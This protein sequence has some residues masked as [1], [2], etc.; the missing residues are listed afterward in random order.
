LCPEASI[1]RARWVLLGAYVAQLVLG[2]VNVILLAPIPIQLFHL[3]LADT[4]WVVFIM[5]VVLALKR[6][7][8]DA[9]AV[10]VA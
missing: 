5:M 4:I 3:L 2:V 1:Y 6:T 10:R 8:A 7:D 9:A